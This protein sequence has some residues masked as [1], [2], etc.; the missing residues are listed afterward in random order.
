MRS[1][2]HYLSANDKNS[3][4]SEDYNTQRDDNYWNKA[5]ITDHQ[6][7]GAIKYGGYRYDDGTRYIGNWNQLGQRHGVGHLLL[8]DKTRYDGCFE[9]NLFSG[10]GCIWFSDGAKLV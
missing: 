4:K 10:K 7:I 9:N 6:I 3:L 2:Q 8:P 1:C 5:T